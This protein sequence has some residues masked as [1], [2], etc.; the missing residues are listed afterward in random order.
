MQ[1]FL[2]RGRPVC[3]EILLEATP[4]RLEACGYSPWRHHREQKD[5]DGQRA[6]ALEGRPWVKA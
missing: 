4:V 6:G 5:V 3:F 2:H 1:E